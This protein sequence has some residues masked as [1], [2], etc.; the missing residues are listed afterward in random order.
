MNMDADMRTS[1]GGGGWPDADRCGQGGV[2]GQNRPIFCGCP[3][4]TTPNGSVSMTKREVP[5]C[6]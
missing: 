3:L 2:G 5:K 1:A 4:C 6:C